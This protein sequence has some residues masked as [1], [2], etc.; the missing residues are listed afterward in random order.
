MFLRSAGRV[1]IAAS[2]LTSL[3]LPVAADELDD[4]STAPAAV[5]AQATPA[6][7]AT[8]QTAPGAPTPAQVNPAAGASPSPSPAPSPAPPKRLRIS[9]QSS[10]SYV[11]QQFV[12]PG[13]QPAEGPLFAAGSP[14]A[15]GTPYDFWTS[16]PTT[17]GWGI[18]ET[19]LVTPTYSLSPS[20]D[21]SLTAGYGALS[22]TGSVAGYWGDQPLATLNPHLGMRSV[23]LPVAFT[24]SN[25]QDGISGQRGSILSGAIGKHDGTLTLRG[26]WFDPIQT[27]PFVFRQ[28]PQTNTPIL[29]TE[30]LPEGL[31]DPPQTLDVLTN[32]RNNLPL[33]GADLF[34]KRGP[35]SF[36]AFDANLPM[37]IGTSARVQSASLEISHNTRLSYGAEIAGVSVSGGTV[38]TTIM[39]GGN[40]TLT[41]SV[42]GALPTSTLNAQK[43]VSGGVRA[44]FPL[45]LDT[46]GQVRIATSCYSATG[47]AASSSSCTQGWYYEAKIHHGFRAFDAAL[48]F[49]RSDATYATAILPYG[50]LENIWSAPWTWPGTWLK[51]TYQFVDNS[52]M[53]P[54]RQGVR[55]SANTIFKG[56]E[57]RAAYA[58]FNQIRPY[59]ASTAFIP[60]FVEGF[61]LPQLNAPG[62]LGHEQHAALSLLWHPAFA[63]VDLDMTDVTMSRRGSAGNPNEAVAMDYPSATLTLSKQLSE[64]Y[65]LSAGASSYG[66]NGAFS[67][68]GT[69]NVNLTE[70]V[71]FAGLQ[72]KQNATSAWGVQYRLYNTIGSTTYPGPFAPPGTPGT[73]TG[74]GPVLPWYRGP[75]WI[76]ENRFRT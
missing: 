54:N 3:L 2:F 30:P 19:F 39:F 71:I 50:V 58:L 64:K 41:P 53:G 52:V 66:N 4:A 29:F 44:T 56:I 49:M 35:A 5:V 59:D 36:E 6:P 40:P 16:S 28:P 69:K 72:W 46:D 7:S 24:T 57:V 62:T 74:S 12:G 21:V 13:L 8:P 61:F 67:T 70:E 65:L 34:V 18:N 20:L 60:G 26:G 23:P 37:L 45:S 17:V 55:A 38:P 22:G 48:D 73:I 9:M 47:T 63:D 68:A 10:T 25:G 1:C 75:Q 51:G 15:P 33:Q 42:Y 76:L 43:M 11:N 27:E 31:G 32:V 14:I